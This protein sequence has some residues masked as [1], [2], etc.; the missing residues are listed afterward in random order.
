MINKIDFL[1]PPITLFHLERRTHTSK[2]GACLVVLLLLISTSYIIFILYNLINHKD[3][4]YIFHKKFELEAGYYSFNSSSSFHF[5]QIFSSE[6]GGY[7]GKYESKYIR[8]YTTYTYTNFTYG[9]LDLYDHWVFDTCRKNIDDKDLE[10]YLLGNIENF[11]NGVCIRYYYNSTERKYYSLEDKGFHWPHLQH[12]IFQKNNIYLTTTIQKCSNDS[13]IN[14]ILG[15]CASQREI[16]E[17]LLKYY[18]IYLYFIDTQVDLTNYTMPLQKYLQVIS[19]SIGHK[20]TYAESFIYFSPLRIKTIIGSIFGKTHEFNSFYFDFSRNGDANND[21]EK[22]FTIS[23][24]FHLIQNNVQIY[25]R[26]YNN[27]LDLFSEIGG[28]VQFIFYLFYWINYSYNK[29]IIAYDTNSLFFSMKDERSQR[30][31]HHIN[32]SKNQIN[33][34]GN[35]NTIFNIKNNIINISSNKSK[36]S[37]IKFCNNSLGIIGEVVSKK[38]LK[39]LKSSKNINNINN[40]IISLK[41]INYENNL[42][43]MKMIKPVNPNNKYYQS[44]LNN[45]SNLIIKENNNNFNINDSY[46]KNNTL[47]VQNKMS[48]NL[49]NA[50]AKDKKVEKSKTL[51]VSNKDYIRNISIKKRNIAKIEHIQKNLDL[52]YGKD[53]KKAKRLTFIDFLKSLYFHR[54]KGS[55]HFLTLFR[56]H[57]LSEEHLLKSHINM[58]LF[59]KKYNIND[60]ESTNIYECY[61]EL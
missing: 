19:T 14:E 47:I 29:F 12:G 11:T 10:P 39:S 44:Q 17:Y 34:K 6:N 15:Q 23:K 54:D 45:S 49:I 36:K 9:N 8:A 2:F 33:I 22:Y 40:N 30:L 24:Y 18:A 13:I 58:V 50:I 28:V 1:S 5:I 53:F 61:N 21:D 52:L 46:K 3:I 57:L 27:L 25:E 4:T 16:D 51:Y 42:D 48:N 60:E 41:P 7:F 32:S 35:D 20:K 31:E 37:N 38:D 43:L 26:R 55:H 56:K 59:E